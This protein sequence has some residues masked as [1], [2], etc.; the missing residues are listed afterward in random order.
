MCVLTWW[1][2]AFA[3]LCLSLCHI[4]F[5]FFGLS[6]LTGLA[7][8]AWLRQEGD[9]HTAG[10]MCSFILFVLSAALVRHPLQHFD[11][12]N[13][14]NDRW[15]VMVTV[16]ISPLY[17]LIIGRL[18]SIKQWAWWWWCGL[19]RS[20]WSTASLLP[21]SLSP[22]AHLHNPL[23]V[24]S[25]AALPVPHPSMALWPQQHLICLWWL[26]WRPSDLPLHHMAP[27][28]HAAFLLFN[29]TPLSPTPS[30]LFLPSNVMCSLLYITS[31]FH[32]HT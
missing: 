16:G 5:I 4:I 20:R 2:H 9:Q 14:N 30:F 23:L 28:P 31:H 27:S 1:C 22:P 3:H 29:L 21:A 12:A 18:I 24:S 19:K 11:L 15:V 7:D 32:S 6:C 17:C 26:L 25:P 13:N 8:L 10:Y